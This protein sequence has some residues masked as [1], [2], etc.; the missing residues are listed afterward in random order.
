MTGS[1]LQNRAVCRIVPKK[2]LRNADLDAGRRV[3]RRSR[4]GS[5]LPLATGVF[6]LPPVSPRAPP[7][8]RPCPHLIHALRDDPVR[9]HPSSAGWA[10][11]EGACRYLVPLASA[12]RGILVPESKRA[13]LRPKPETQILILG[14]HE[15]LRGDGWG[16]KAGVLPLA[17]S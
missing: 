1:L 13:A 11:S 17:P 12:G 14:A 5:V 7:R 15:N 10:R 6:L 4:L 8:S 2:A 9:S 3:S 16:G